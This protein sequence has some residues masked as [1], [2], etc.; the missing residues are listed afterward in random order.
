MLYICQGLPAS[1]KDT[2]AL[3]EIEKS[4][5]KLKRLNKDILREMI[6]G[7]KW[8]K[9][10]ERIIINVRNTLTEQWLLEGF[11][12]I[13]TDTN[14]NPKHIVDLAAI[15]KKCKSD[16]T[17]VDHFLDISLRECIRRDA[18]RVNP[19]G[20]KVIT[21]MYFRYIDRK[22]KYLDK[23]YPTLEKDV[24]IVDIDGTVAIHTNRSPYD[25]T[26]VKEDL[27]NLPLFKMLRS[28]QREGI[29]IIFVSGREGTKQ[30]AYDTI[31]W[32]KPHIDDFELFMRQEGDNRK[33][34]IIKEE[35]YF[36]HIYDKYN[37]LFVID[38]RDQTVDMWRNLDLQCWQVNYGSF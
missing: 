22:E 18:G 6:D 21:D 11:D 2:F 36:N 1:G 3:Q 38:D 26:R 24:V 9:E 25:L 7:G 23:M 12:V 37:V 34:S 32:L 31:D 33:D 10:R 35:I 30:C 4:K 15:A 19:V 16:Y 13:I 20:E 14:L 29:K 5:G 8:S 27:P 28:L 17:I